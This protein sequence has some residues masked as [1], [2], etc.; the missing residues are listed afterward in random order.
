MQRRLGP[1]SGLPER[2]EHA[3]LIVPFLHRGDVF[4]REVKHEVSQQGGG[5][6]IS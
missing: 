2:L 5:P 1:M 3:A 6:H 4:E